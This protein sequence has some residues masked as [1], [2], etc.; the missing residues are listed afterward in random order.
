MLAARQVIVSLNQIFLAVFGV[1]YGLRTFLHLVVCCRFL[2]ARD[3]ALL[4]CRLSQIIDVFDGLIYSHWV[5]LDHLIDC[6]S[7]EY[8]ILVIYDLR[9][10]IIGCTFRWHLLNKR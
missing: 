9:A 10:L 3:K 5:R 2:L 6:L 4:L 1:I 7:H 8:S